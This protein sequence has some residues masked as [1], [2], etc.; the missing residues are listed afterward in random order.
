MVWLFGREAIVGDSMLQRVTKRLF[1]VGFSQTQSRHLDGL[2][3][4]EMVGID[5]CW[6]MPTTGERAT[7][8]E[9]RIRG[10]PMSI[11]EARELVINRA[12]DFPGSLFMAKLSKKTPP[13]NSVNVMRPEAAWS[14][15]AG[16][17]VSWD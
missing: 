15:H 16:E 13:Q 14:G 5:E 17:K 12:T 1:G 9:K 8:F 4:M 11:R 7:P 3:R 10:K 2:A 6:L